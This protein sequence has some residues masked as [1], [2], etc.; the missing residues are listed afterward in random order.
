MSAVSPYGHMDASYILYTQ[1]AMKGL[2]Y[3][4]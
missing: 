2:K 3:I 4:C 1:G